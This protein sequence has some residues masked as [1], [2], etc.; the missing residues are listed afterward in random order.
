MIDI[1][2]NRHLHIARNT[3]R[4]RLAGTTCENTDLQALENM[5]HR[6]NS[7]QFDRISMGTKD[8]QFDMRE[9][10][11]TKNRRFCTPPP[12]VRHPCSAV[13]SL[14]WLFLAE[15]GLPTHAPCQLTAP[16]KEGPRGHIHKICTLRPPL[17]HL[18]R[19]RGGLIYDG[20]CISYTCMERIREHRKRQIQRMHDS[21]DTNS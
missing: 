12:R 11:L 16:E 13:C 19:A 2:T 8:E 9:L 6:R 17:Q 10:I 7:R 3:H 4:Q 1:L 14:S 18:L 20:T 21:A 15:G 5:D